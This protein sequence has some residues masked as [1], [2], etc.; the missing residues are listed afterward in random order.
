MGV[1][2]WLSFTAADGLLQFTVKAIKA[3]RAAE[4]TSPP[5][6][7][8]HDVVTWCFSPIQT[9]PKIYKPLFSASASL[10]F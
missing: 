9:V 6:I 7:C 2:G 10:A 4:S 3:P 5:S 8:M 1:D